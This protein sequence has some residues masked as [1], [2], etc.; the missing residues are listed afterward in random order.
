MTQS[1]FTEE[2][3]LELPAEVSRPGRDAAALLLFTA[4]TAGTS[5]LV[6]EWRIYARL[7]A[8]A[9]VPLNALDHLILAWTV[10]SKSMVLM[11][12][13]LLIA[14]LLTRRGRSTAAWISI[15]SVAVMV[16]TAMSVDLLIY[17]AYGRHLRDLLDYV[18][19]PQA[20]DYIGGIARW[21]SLPAVC[22]ASVSIAATSLM[23]VSRQLSSRVMRRFGRRNGNREATVVAALMGLLILAPLALRNYTGRE[24]LFEK[25][26]AI[27]ALD[28]RRNVDR[29]QPEAFADPVLSALDHGLRKTYRQ[30]FPSLLRPAPA[31]PTA[32]LDIPDKPNVIFIVLESLNYEEA[33]TKRAMPKLAAW[34]TQGMDFQRHYAGA[35]HSEAGLFTLLYARNAWS[36]HTVLDTGVPPQ[37]CTTFGNSGYRTAYFSGWNSNWIRIGS[38][39]SPRT[40][41]H[42][43][44]EIARVEHGR[45][46]VNWDR[47]ALQRLREAV[48]AAH[49]QPLF[50]FCFLISSHLPYTYPPE[51]ENHPTIGVADSQ[52]PAALHTNASELLRDYH[53][54]LAFLDDELAATIAEL[55]P[56]RNVIVVTGDHGESIYHDGTY[57]HQTRFSDAQTRVPLF[58]VG[59]GI[60]KLTLHTATTHADVLPTLLHALSG[61]HVPIAGSTGRDLLE[62]PAADEVLLC[63]VKINGSVKLLALRGENRLAFDADSY[64]PRLKVLGFED[65]HGRSLIQ[66]GQ[67]LEDV[68]A[69]LGLVRRN[70]KPSPE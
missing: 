53:R 17:E 28:L 15:L 70:L 26:C 48:T 62:K 33:V 69:W 23:Y 10:W 68:E 54:C 61:H 12:P 40:F 50:A 43:G 20:L 18:Y 47:L 13:V 57:S 21:L 64:S 2:S 37:A 16:H 66:H 7:L 63:S 8:P 3:I 56:A 65:H 31:D 30:E 6:L 52:I 22:F 49:E 59:P 1:S 45:P 32:V 36:F 11:L 34:G 5:L 42:Y 4:L 55:D 27:F 9:D 51:Y 19:E 41:D 46:W 38:F 24:A 35:N 29:F 25:T 67:R 14:L 39:I 58:I 44:F 60:P